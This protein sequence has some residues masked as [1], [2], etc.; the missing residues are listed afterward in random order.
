PRVHEAQVHWAPDS[1]SLSYNQIRELPA[2]SPPTETFLDT[3]AFLLRVGAPERSARPLFGPL[4][5]KDL[6]LDRLDVAGVNFDPTSRFMVARSP[7]ATTPSRPKAATGSTAPRSA[8]GRCVTA[9]SITSRAWR[10][11]M[12]THG[13][14]PAGRQPTT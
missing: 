5:N 7:R 6:K 14:P 2:G 3:T 11:P 9:A 1:R 12:P 4:V 13:L 8:G 10:T